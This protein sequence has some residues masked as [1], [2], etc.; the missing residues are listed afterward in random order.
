M[1]ASHEGFT[2]PTPVA[3]DNSMKRNQLRL[4]FES[5]ESR[6]MMAGDVG[7]AAPAV[8]APP[9]FEAP[10]VPVAEIA[11]APLPAAAVE[12]TEL[13]G[14]AVDNVFADLSETGAEPVAILD[15]TVE[16]PVDP[17]SEVEDD[18]I[19]IQ[20]AEPVFQL[21]PGETALID[22]VLGLDNDSELDSIIPFGIELDGSIN[23]PLGGPTLVISESALPEEATQPES[24]N[25]EIQEE[26][27][28]SALEELSLSQAS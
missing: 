7:V 22:G 3:R 18:F 13:P 10:A 1:A 14:E 19:P 21:Q 6:N 11:F 23:P 20:V 4:R 15:E 28:P 27:D 2:P 26:L 24:E 16:E 25:P 17:V 8:F 5:L 12:S 9:V